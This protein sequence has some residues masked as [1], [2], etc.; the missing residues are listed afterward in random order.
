MLIMNGG[1]LYEGHWS[2][3]LSYGLLMHPFVR[4]GAPQ[5][6]KALPFFSDVIVNPLQ[7]APLRGG[8]RGPVVKGEMQKHVYAG[9]YWLPHR[10]WIPYG[11]K[12]EARKNGNRHD[13]VEVWLEGS[14]DRGFVHLLFALLCALFH[15]LMN[16][17][18]AASTRGGAVSGNLQ[19][20]E[21]QVQ[22]VRRKW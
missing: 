5:L 2:F 12:A 14:P 22:V 20:V 11:G 18:S 15:V 9:P 16:T 13:G 7:G 3:R 4:F 19:D 10:C 21:C 6:G 1:A 17:R 8:N